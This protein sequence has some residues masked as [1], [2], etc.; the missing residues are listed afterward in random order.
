MSDAAPRKCWLIGRAGQL[1]KPL[2]DALTDAGLL[3]RRFSSWQEANQPKQIIAD[4]P[5]LM[6]VAL[7]PRQDGQPID[8]CAAQPATSPDACDTDSPVIQPIRELERQAIDAALRKFEGSVSDAAKALGI[9][10]ATVY[11]K[12]KACGLSH[13]LRRARLPR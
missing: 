12:V 1:E 5:E 6:L 10:E 8:W 7:E 3:V 9:S 4:Q 2:Y 13:H 11:R